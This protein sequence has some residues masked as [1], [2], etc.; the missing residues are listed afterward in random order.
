MSKKHAT[1]GVYLVSQ[2][3]FKDWDSYDSFVCTAQ[4]EEE[5][6]NLYPGGGTLL[7]LPC[8]YQGWPGQDKKSSIRVVQIGISF[9]QDTQ[10][11]CASFNAG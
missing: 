9:V 3:I 10:V 1:Y 8:Y 6:R 5:A 7:E 11:V 2:D 4:D